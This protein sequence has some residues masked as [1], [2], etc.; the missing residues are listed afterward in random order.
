VELLLGCIADGTAALWCVERLPESP[1]GLKAAFG[2][3]DSED[4]A[5]R[6]AAADL[7]LDRLARDEWSSLVTAYMR[8]WHYYNVLVALDRRLHP[9]PW[10]QPT[11]VALPAATSPADS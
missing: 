3:V 1:E 6:A 4:H 10:E 2:L 7:I 8:G 11:R 9:L 5:V